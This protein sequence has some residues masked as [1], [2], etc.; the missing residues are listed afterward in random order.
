MTILVTGA[1]GTVG[2][3]FAELAPT[4]HE[5][6]D[7]ATK[8]DLDVSNL[9]AVRSSAG[10]LRYSAMI[11]LAAATDVDR[12][13][14]DRAWAHKL[15]TVGAWNLAL[16]ASEIGAD[17]VQVS[18]TQ[19]FGGDGNEGPFS[20]L[21]VPHAPNFYAK[22]KLAG[23]DMVRAVCP[24]AFIVRTAWVM[25][26]GE[27]DKKFV[28]KV[29]DKLIAGQPVKAVNDQFGSPTYARHLVIAIR[30][31]LKTRAYGLYHATNRGTASRYDMALEMKKILGSTSTVEPVSA[32]AFPLPAPRP[33]SD[34]SLGL[35]LPARGL[36][37]LL[38]TWQDALAEYLAS[39]RR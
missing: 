11:N 28:G 22:T 7:L 9:E 5:P 24:R 13:E 14:T 1:G 26:G 18:T 8:S 19:I 33:K 6:L 2:A 20:E 27:K 32:T 3:Y 17:L 4:F 30:E 16:A 39:W 31:L 37:E 12:C 34:A 15:N 36:G 35:N 29:A 23:E 25:G 38:P 10:R 21:D